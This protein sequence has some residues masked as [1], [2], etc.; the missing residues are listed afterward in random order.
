MVRRSRVNKI[1]RM[2]ASDKHEGVVDVTLIRND[3]YNTDMKEN[4][5]VQIDCHIVVDT[6]NVKVKVENQE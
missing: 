4:Y 2:H 6:E 1:V 5:P 3:G